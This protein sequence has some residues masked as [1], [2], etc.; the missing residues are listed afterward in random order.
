MGL[1]FACAFCRCGFRFTL[2]VDLE[3]RGVEGVVQGVFLY[4]QICGAPHDFWGLQGFSDLS[5]FSV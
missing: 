4:F 5:G 1:S 2:H 3:N